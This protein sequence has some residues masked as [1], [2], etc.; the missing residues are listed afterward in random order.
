M[1]LDD[2]RIATPC[3][4]SWADMSGDDR[5]RQCAECR[6]NVYNLSAM[7]RAEATAFLEQSEGRVCVRFYRR[8]DGTVLTSDC[9]V[10]LATTARLRLG[11]LVAGLLAM[12]SA[13]F[14]AVGATHVDWRNSSLLKPVL[15]WFE[16]DRLIQGERV[17]MGIAPPRRNR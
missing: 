3:P 15:T 7:T 14:W 1:T 16:G 10:G 11:K 2:V 5:K 4:A 6:L 13:V 17:T 8:I 9:P 12:A